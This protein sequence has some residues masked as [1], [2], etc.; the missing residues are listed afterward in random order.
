MSEDS[1]LKGTAS[2]ARQLAAVGAAELEAA[3][4]AASLGGLDGVELQELLDAL[5]G[6]AGADGRGAGLVPGSPA[7]APAH[8]L[9]HTLALS[10]SLGPGSLEPRRSPSVSPSPTPSP[11]LGDN[12]SPSAS[13]AASS[14]GAD[15]NLRVVIRVRPP[16]EHELRGSLGHTYQA[17]TRVE[18]GRHVT[19]LDVGP[20]AVAL[21]GGDAAS[22][23]PSLSGYAAASF[24]FDRVFDQSARQREV[25][26]ASVRE[27][28]ASC[29]EGY[30]ATILAY[31]QTGTGKTYTMEGDPERF[32]ERGVVPRAIEQIFSH[33]QEKASGSVR[34]LVRASYLQIY[35]DVIFDLLRADNQNLTI[36]EEDRAKKNSRGVY[37]DGLSEWVVRSPHE[38][39]LLMA[40]GAERRATGRTKL[41]DLSSR[42]HAILRLIVEQVETSFADAASGRA[43][44]PEQFEKRAAQEAAANPRVD[45]SKFVRQRFRV[46]KL[47]LVDLAGSERVH[48]SGATGVRLEE[49]KRINRSLSSLGNVIAALTTERRAHIPYRDSKLTRILEDSLGGNCKTVFL[50]MVSPAADALSET[51]STLKFAHRAKSIQNTAFVN[52]DL[53]RNSLLR[54][55][56]KELRKLRK[57]LKLKSQ[58]VVDQRVVLELEDQK[59]RA[60]ADKIA[61]LRALEAR[62]FEFM[63]EKLEKRMLEEKILELEGQV[64]SGGAHTA[65]A[66]GTVGGGSGAHVQDSPAFRQ[67]ISAHRDAL[68]QEYQQ[69]MDEVDR[70]RE[71]IELHKTQVDRYKQLLLKQR[72]IMVALTQRL[73]E[74][75]EQIVA[76]QDELD[77]TE[78]RHAETQ[79]HLDKKTADLIHAHKLN[80]EMAQ[81]GTTPRSRGSGAGQL[82]QQL[83]QQGQQGGSRTS[84]GDAAEDGDATTPPAGQATQSAVGLEARVRALTNQYQA[85]RDEVT[86]RMEKKD[87]LIVALQQEIEQLR[88][89]ATGQHGQQRGGDEQDD[90]VDVNSELVAEVA[91][92][93]LRATNHAKEQLAIRT[94]MEKINLLA[95]NVA[96]SDA[97]VDNKV[98]PQLRALCSLVSASCSALQHST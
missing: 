51:L 22:V 46:A 6:E 36:R 67:A 64:L 72:D 58:A 79:E 73:N 66:S 35:N 40:E 90:D 68:R 43:L 81:S 56:E 52:E 75:D 69:R 82:E 39:F 86:A 19:V 74:R 61:A 48:A 89:S 54:Q 63:K 50:A 95:V 23:A 16:L 27:L 41:N 9:A 87:D 18:G 98:Q 85:F 49:S 33:I 65:G 77:E 10:L 59:R 7:P 4:G 45:L 15:R 42:S 30:N 34:F 21:S 60:E 25:Y 53:D 26:D 32:E 80:E 17:C 84:S 83:L 57:E 91:R 92:L 13:G 14:G 44:S 94:I 11:A 97:L 5:E 78:K 2:A 24:T 76:L 38:I 47:N 8:A 31:G 28:V 93:R 37:V 55:Y 29:L 3:L 62:S 88:S 70:E 96:S 1:V 12:A 20:P 71:Q